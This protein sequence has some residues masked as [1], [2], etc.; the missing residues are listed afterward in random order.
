MKTRQ[1]QITVDEVHRVDVNVSVGFWCNLRCRHCA[2]EFHKSQP[3]L[4]TD[5]VCAEIDRHRMLSAGRLVLTGGEPTLRKDL[6]TIIAHAWT[7]GFRSIHL[8][9]N[10]TALSHRPLVARLTRAGLTSALVS[11][12]G[13]TADIHDAITRRRGSF[14][15]TIR[16]LANLIGAGIKVA[17]NTV[18][19]RANLNHLATLAR[20][21]TQRFPEVHTLCFSYPQA[22]GGVLKDFT[23]LT[24]RLSETMPHL[25]AALELATECGYWTWVSD[26]PLCYM[27]GYEEHSAHVFPRLTVASDPDPEAG[28]DAILD[29]EGQLRQAKVKAPVCRKCS[30]TEICIGVDR[31]YADH[32]GLEELS[33]FKAESTPAV[34]K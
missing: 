2:V 14:E 11:L 3:D 9:T 12:L 27:P 18:I 21:I 23:G 20:F 30:L 19:S 15:K 8:Q 16:G 28:D 25:L 22:S 13:P 33:P 10:A 17:T 26:F 1:D 4:T 31:V 24:P 29:F 34:P 5:E 32:Y 6:P 7:V